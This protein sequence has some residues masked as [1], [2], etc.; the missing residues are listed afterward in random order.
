MMRNISFGVPR[1]FIGRIYDLKGSQYDREVLNK[2]PE[3]V[4]ISSFILKDKD[5]DKL[6]K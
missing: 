3:G 2:I 6:E 1:E 5:F 4:N